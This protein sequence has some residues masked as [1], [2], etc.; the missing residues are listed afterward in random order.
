M[1]NFIKLILVVS[2][3]FLGSCKKKE[4][5]LKPWGKWILRDAVMY[6]TYENGVKEKYA[7]FSSS[8][9]ISSLR[10]DGEIL[11][12]IEKIEKNVT[13]WSF[14]RPNSSNGTGDSVLNGDETKNYLIQYYGKNM[15]IIESDELPLQS[16][17]GGSSRPIL[18]ETIDSK[19]KMITVKIQTVVGSIN[20]KNCEY[21]TSLTMERIEDF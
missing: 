6:V 5:E 16:N 15:S 18:G 19:N 4:L 10:Y 2:V 1:K 8:K 14:Y 9:T 21:Y 11:F 12:D 17:L 7:H 20:G 13:T 3:L